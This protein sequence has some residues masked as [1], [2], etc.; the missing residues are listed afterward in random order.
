MAE[1][2]HFKLTP[3]DCSIGLLNSSGEN[4]FTGFARENLEH[5]LFFMNHGNALSVCFIVCL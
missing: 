4:C 1:R 2:V 5:F 3:L